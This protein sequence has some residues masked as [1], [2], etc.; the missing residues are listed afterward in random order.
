M[1][2][3]PIMKLKFNMAVPCSA[4]HLAEET[5]VTALCNHSVL[6]EYS[7]KSVY[8]KLAITF[9]CS[10]IAKKN[11][12][13]GYKNITDLN[14]TFCYCCICREVGE[15]RC[16]EINRV[17]VQNIQR[18]AALTEWVRGAGSYVAILSLPHSIILLDLNFRE[19]HFHSRCS[20]PLS[21]IKKKKKKSSSHK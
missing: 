5:K 8:R 10:A 13:T 21:L 6:S 12:T 15:R 17:Q 18:E 14:S 7:S 20:R 19:K 11:Q 4:P 16:F 2:V 3:P 9:C 1:T